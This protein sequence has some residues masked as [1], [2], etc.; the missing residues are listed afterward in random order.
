M[1]T[2]A[3]PCRIVGARG[4]GHHGFLPTIPCASKI[5]VT[6]HCHT[7]QLSPTPEPPA[8]APGSHC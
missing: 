8:T 7:A 2:L 6:S 1:W 5:K 4:L 3:Q